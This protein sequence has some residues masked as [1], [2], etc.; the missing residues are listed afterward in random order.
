VPNIQQKYT[1]TRSSSV[2]E[3][4]RRFRVVNIYFWWII[5][6]FKIIIVIFQWITKI[7]RLQY[8]VHRFFLDQHAA[9]K[10]IDHWVQKVFFSYFATARTIFY[11]VASQAWISTSYFF[12]HNL[13]IIQKSNWSNLINFIKISTSIRLHPPEDCC[14][15][16]I[17]ST[18]SYWSVASLSS[19]ASRQVVL[20]SFLIA[21]SSYCW[22]MTS[23]SS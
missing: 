11:A 21:A 20:L 16:G 3:N 2:P 13:L 22:T 14:L 10:I 7:S 18:W 15:V 5:V 8:L 19:W 4:Q 9:Q 1:T 17:L 6:F 23:L 12:V